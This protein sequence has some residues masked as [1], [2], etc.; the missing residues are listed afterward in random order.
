VVAHTFNP[1]TQEAEAGGFLSSRPVRGL[2]SKFQDSQGYT[3]KPCLKKKQQQQ[4]KIL[5]I[6]YAVTRD[7]SG[8]IYSMLIVCLPK[9]NCEFLKGDFIVCKL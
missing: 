2:Q 5:S 3:E 1:N 6:G 8:K 7:W 9:Q 4:Q